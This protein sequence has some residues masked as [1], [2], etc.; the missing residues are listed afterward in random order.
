MNMLKT[1]FLLGAL[2]GLVLGAGYYFGGEQG[3]TIAFIIAVVMNAGSYWFSDRIVLRIYRAKVVTP[4]QAPYLHRI[5]DDL[6]SR[7]GMTKPKIAIV[8]LPVP[9][10]FATGRNKHHAVVAVSPSITE[11]LSEPELRAV[12]AH[13]LGHIKN[14]DILISSAAATL[15]GVISYLAQ[16]VIWFGGGGR[17]REGGNVFGLLAFAILTPLMATIIQLAISR[18]REFGADA[19]S[20]AIT[21]DPNDLAN[22]L[23]KLD[24][25]AHRTPLKGQPKHEATAH[26]FIVNPFKSSLLMRL[27]STHPPMEE[28]IAKLEE[29]AGGA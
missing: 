24:Q 13:E 3:L 28:R 6:V 25:I 5:I 8:N 9:N 23:R 18:T 1:V 22:A 14:R 7:A 26:M 20:A 16:M 27:F 19:E 11:V 12:L 17:S 4:E 15:A 10:A 21:G 29:M 2:T